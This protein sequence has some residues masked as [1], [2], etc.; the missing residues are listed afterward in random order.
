MHSVYNGYLAYSNH[1]SSII[2]D[3]KCLVSNVINEWLVYAFQP[4][5]PSSVYTVHLTRALWIYYG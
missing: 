2:A 5:L 4:S 1:I 3:V